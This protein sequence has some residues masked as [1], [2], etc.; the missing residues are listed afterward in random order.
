MTGGV[1]NC[2]RDAVGC[3]GTQDATGQITQGT[4]GEPGE[5][6]VNAEFD[7]PFAPIEPEVCMTR[8]QCKYEATVVRDF[9]RFQPGDL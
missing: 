6:F 7:P 9:T 3:D 2:P 1:G 4:R 5:C 8:P